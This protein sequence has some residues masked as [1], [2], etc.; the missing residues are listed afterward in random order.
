MYLCESFFHHTYARVI[1]EVNDVN[2]FPE[3]SITFKLEQVQML[4]PKF[5]PGFLLLRKIV[6]EQGLLTKKWRKVCSVTEMLIYGQ[7]VKKWII[8]Q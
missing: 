7:M 2:I 3:I 5:L 1:S 4:S 8:L 6:W